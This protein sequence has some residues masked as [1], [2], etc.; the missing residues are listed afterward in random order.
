MSHIVEF[1]IEGLAGSKIPYKKKLNRDVNIFFGLNGSGKT[2]L[3]KILHSAMSNNAIPLI[4]VPFKNAR[5]IIYSIKYKQ[6]ITYSIEKPKISETRLPKEVLDRISS[7]V[8]REIFIRNYIVHD[9]V[10]FEWRV[11][12]KRKDIIE[13]SWQH[14]YLPTTRLLTGYTG[15]QSAELRR[16]TY[17]VDEDAINMHMESELLRQWNEYFGKVQGEVRSIQ[18]SGLAEVLKTVLGTKEKKDLK[19]LDWKEAYKLAS[20]F[21]RKQDRHAQLENKEHFKKRYEKDEMLPRVIRH[22]N[23]IEV[24]VAKKL[25]PRDLLQELINKLFYRK[26]LELGATSIDIETHGKEKIRVAHLSSGEKQVLYILIQALRSGE[27]SLI[28]DEPEISMHIDWQK[29]LI[30][31]LTRLNPDNQLIIATHSPEIMAD[32]SEDKIFRL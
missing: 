29:A 19:K 9:R 5:I 13:A 6:E 16:T 12:P 27:S 11:S 15:P 23:N 7:E 4:D 10:K 2:S 21:I 31:A 30:P 26:K 28:I 22:I 25:L 14:R 1:S 32:L 17:E 18:E 3:L 20:T 8:E 24:K